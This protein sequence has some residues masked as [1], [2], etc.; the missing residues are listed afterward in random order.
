MSMSDIRKIK[1]TAWLPL[2]AMLF[3]MLHAAHAPAQTDADS[4]AIE[5]AATAAP[6]Q[7]PVPEQYSTARKTLRTFFE[8]EK[9]A[10]KAK[11]LN[12]E[13]FTAEERSAHGREI[14][15]K[16]NQILDRIAI[17]E[18]E[19]VP[20][21]A[22]EA[23]FM[24][25]EPRVS[26]ERAAN[27]RFLF[28]ARTMEQ[29]DDLFQQ[30]GGDQIVEG[31]EQHKYEDMPLSFYIRGILP[32]SMLRQTL[33]LENWQWIGL[34]IIILL[35][36]IASKI[37]QFL[38]NGVTTRWASAGRIALH[39][40]HKLMTLRA[41]GLIVMGGVW[42]FGVRWL[43]L[44]VH[45]ATFLQFLA[46]III[47]V[48]SVVAVYRMVDVLCSYLEERAGKTANK[49]DD[50]LVP[51]VRKSLKV[52]VVAIG[53]V[54]IADNLY[55]DV[56]S[57]LAGLGI[58]G[59]ALAFAAKDTI[60]NFFGSVML[61]TDRPFNVGDWVI[62]D[63]AEGSVEELGF[64]STRIR[65]FYN[66]QVTIPNSVLC[67]KIIDNMGA[68]TYRRFKTYIQVTYDTP[69]EKIQEF[70][71]GIKQLV[72]NNPHMR[73]D[74]FHIYLNQFGAHSLDILLYIFFH[75]PD[76]G[77]EL[78]ERH[79]LMLEIIK[80]AG[81]IGVEFAFPTQTLHLINEANAGIPGD[82]N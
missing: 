66:S 34:L 2:L 15:L 67:N 80:L 20:D 16:L 52:L 79:N 43:G 62:V 54:F 46:Q 8:T 71:D 45:I 26:I 1:P 42:W 81:R 18:M 60:A 33:I 57:L 63:G 4:P 27:G 68:R 72:L 7:L 48:A 69:P 30:Y 59:L 78:R 73:H 36:F 40:K 10:D 55:E 13:N 50:L 61:L 39:E 3:L 29:I 25:Q 82:K 19:T 53:A 65:T 12:L 21:S 70:T 24:P 17:V 11:C 23:W 22:D 31:L 28:S 5:T 38:I 56:Y 9:L 41:L 77:A 6:A 75:V 49:F 58:G 32:K 74:Y 37:A 14:A 35:G 44:P 47:C 76:W 51:M 64:R